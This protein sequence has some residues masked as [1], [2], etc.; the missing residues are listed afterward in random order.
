MNLRQIPKTSYYDDHRC[1]YLELY[2]KMYPI[3]D[4]RAFLYYFGRLLIPYDLQCFGE[5]I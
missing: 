5:D 3:M 4:K 2:N 1:V